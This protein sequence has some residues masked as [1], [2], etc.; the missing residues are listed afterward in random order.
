MINSIQ[1]AYTAQS[2]EANDYTYKLKDTQQQRDQSTDSVNFSD[3]SKMISSFF[4]GLGVEY[5]PGQS[6][7]MGDL[8]GGLKNSTKEFRDRTDS[9]FLENGIRLNPPIELTS[10]FE[11][12]IRVKEDHP[13]KEKIEQLFEENP[14]LRNKFA[15]ISALNS[16]VE[17][18]KEYIEFSKEYA[19]NPQAAVAKYGHMLD[20]LKNDE[21]SMIFSAEEESNTTA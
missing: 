7:T 21:F 13:Q 2:I 1:S 18:G 15:G 3:S 9:L 17:A 8:E 20:S 14:D 11:G 5:T 16:L 12:K 4:S 19:K 10:D 6:V